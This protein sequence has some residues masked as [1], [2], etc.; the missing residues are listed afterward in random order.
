MQKKELIGTILDL[1]DENEKLKNIVSIQLNRT[2]QEKREKLKEPDSEQLNS[3]K[4]P[5]SKIE[6]I[7]KK[8]I[9]KKQTHSWYSPNI[10][11]DKK[12]INTFEEY[13]SNIRRDYFPEEFDNVG[14]NDIIEYFKDV[15]YEQYLEQINDYKAKQKEEMLNQLEEKSN[16]D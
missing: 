14:M 1:F 5:A 10:L 11:N 12:Q 2:L 7:V 8:L 6:L 15:L 13:L 3:L 9:I 4:E 16:E